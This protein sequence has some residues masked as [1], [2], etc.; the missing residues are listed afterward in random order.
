MRE[1]NTRNVGA[2]GGGT[3]PA[4]R[5]SG[6]LQARTGP[7]GIGTP[8]NGDSIYN[9]AIDNP[10]AADRLEL[11]RHGRR[12]QPNRGVRRCFCS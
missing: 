7:L 4:Q 3:D 12:C 1:L 2:A 5:R 10:P 6:D 9:G 8:V 11:A